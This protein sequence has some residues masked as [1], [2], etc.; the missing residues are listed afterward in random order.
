MTSYR[1][2]KIRLRDWIKLL[3]LKLLIDILKFG[4]EHGYIFALHYCLGRMYYLEDV[5]YLVD[6]LFSDDF[7]NGGE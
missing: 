4:K 6:D 7:L 2:K 3:N 1:Y 5:E